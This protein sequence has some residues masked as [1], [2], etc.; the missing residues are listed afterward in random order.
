M[1]SPPTPPAS[2][3]R[4]SD[5]SD[6]PLSTD[7]R[8][9]L[10]RDD[11]CVHIFTASSTLVGVCVTVIGLLRLIRRLQGVTS[12]ADVLLGVDALG[13][14][15]SCVIAY[16][17]LRTSR[18]ARRRRIERFADGTFLLSLALMAVV[19]FLVAFELV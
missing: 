1:S 16:G 12:I 8:A 7:L 6:D 19:C 11:I 15:A 5:A 3:V 17:A 14:L 9:Q 10:R 2:L 13:F 18:L 4:T